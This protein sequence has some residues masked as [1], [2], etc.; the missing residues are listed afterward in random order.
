MF[1]F[2][3]SQS[4]FMTLPCRYDLFLNKNRYVME[5]IAFEQDLSLAW[6][7]PILLFRL[8]DQS[9]PGILLS[10]SL[11]LGKAHATSLC[12][13]TWILK[14]ELRSS[15]FTKGATI[16]SQEKSSFLTVP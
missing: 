3:V 10:V 16:P 13:S 12:L 9:T 7:T 8:A 14:V 15:Y 5:S 4:K 2:L 1:L 11:P 6:S